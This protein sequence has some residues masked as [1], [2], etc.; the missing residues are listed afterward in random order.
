MSKYTKIL[1]VWIISLGTLAAYFGY[2]LKNWSNRPSN[3][4]SDTEFDLNKGT[5]LASLSNNLEALGAID[6]A[7]KFKWSVK[8]FGDYSRFQAGHYLIEARKSPSEIADVFTTGKSYS[9]VILTIVI[10]EGFTLN[11]ILN[12]LEAKGLGS[13][14]ELSKLANNRDFIRS[15][16]V[17]AKTLEGFLYPA[18]Y[19]YVR[20]RT[21]KQVISDMIETFW[22]KLPEN[23]EAE[24]NKRGLTLERAVTFASLIEMETLLD[25]ERPKVSEVIW[26]RLKNG[27]P[28]AIDAALIYGIKNYKGNIRWRHL[29]DRK[30]KYNTRIYKGLP[31]T[32]IGSVSVESLKAVLNPSSEGYY[33]YVL[34]PDSSK[35]HHFSK[36]L[37][38]HNRHVQKLVKKQKGK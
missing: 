28:L 36:T 4:T 7:F 8:L 35:S 16:K 31:P 18:T 21:G 20:E 19:S 12:R 27:E 33:Y 30:N 11:K 22:E 3:L 14:K 26:A 10:P 15:L 9:P 38:E 17:P 2:E 37:Q 24:V 32:P 13:K 34:K 1:V 25:E 6:S 29:K 23:Y 5:S